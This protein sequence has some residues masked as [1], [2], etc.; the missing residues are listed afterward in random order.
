MRLFSSVAGTEPS[1][2]FPK[3]GGAT[4]MYHVLLRHLSR[5]CL[6]DFEDKLIPRARLQI[7]QGNIKGFTV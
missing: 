4:I 3:Y 5:T 6:V 2:M 7:T 1:S